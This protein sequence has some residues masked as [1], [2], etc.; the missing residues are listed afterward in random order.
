VEVPAEGKKRFRTEIADG[1]RYVVR[2]PLLRP[3]AICTGSSNL[4]SNIAFAV[5]ILYAVRNLSLNA[6]EIGVIFA[7]G[8]VGALLGAVSG[9]AIARRLGIG[10]AIVL[11][12]LIF[13]PPALLIP[14]AP[15]A[16]PY[17]F[18]ILALLIGSFGSVV[19]NV[20]QVG[21]RQAITPL[22]MQ[23]RMNATMR[24]M[25]WGT[26]PIG[27]FLGGVLG[28]TIGL[29]ATLWVSAI[30]SLLPFLPVLFSPVRSLQTIPEMPEEPEDVLEATAAPEVVPR[31]QL[32]PVDTADD[33]V[34]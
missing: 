33:S 14:L 3:I 26:I 32:P 20:N 25:V 21:L 5:F 30:G 19:Y 12:A 28:N 10:P 16:S 8:N 24:F 34:I 11:A 2:H 15:A 27:A 23:G 4:F 13:G 1:L 7:V 17:A 31:S 9:S 22:R 29:K 18:L 6:G